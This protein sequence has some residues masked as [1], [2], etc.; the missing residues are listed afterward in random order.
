MSVEEMVTPQTT[1]DGKGSAAGKVRT[2]G[3][4]TR[5]QNSSIAMSSAMLLIRGTYGGYFSSG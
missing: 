5:R 2:S 3:P 4:A 1:A